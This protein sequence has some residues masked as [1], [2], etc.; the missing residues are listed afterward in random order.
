MGR[1]PGVKTIRRLANIAMGKKRVRRFIKNEL[2]TTQ[3]VL[4][5]AIANAVGDVAHT[6]QFRLSDMDQSATFTAL[7]DSYRIDKVEMIFLPRAVT[8]NEESSAIGSVPGYMLITPDYD[9]AGTITLAG[10]REYDKCRVWNTINGKIHKMTVVPR[11]SA[12]VYG[13]GAFTSYAESPKNIWYD[14]ASPNIDFYGVKLVFPA[15]GTASTVIY[16]VQCL[17]TVS[18]KHVR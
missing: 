4:K 9:D 7:F 3:V 2:T 13:A 17:Y 10:I 14:C 18:F 11:T 6:Y 8:T 5:T 1:R 12:A 15:A 16:D